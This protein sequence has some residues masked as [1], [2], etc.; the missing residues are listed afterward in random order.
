MKLAVSNLAWEV[1]GSDKIH[2]HLVDNGIHNV[3]GVLT[4][5]AGWE[6]LA[7]YMLT[8]HKKQLADK[9]ISI[10]TLQAIFYNSPC[11]DLSQEEDVLLHFSKVIWC[12]K[13]LGTSILVFGA[14][15]LRRVGTGT[16]SDIATLFK[17]LD[18]LLEGTG[19]TVVIEPNAREYGGEFFYTVQ[20][21][22]E[23]IQHNELHNVATMI[24]T[25]N[26]YLENTDPSVELLQYFS[27]IKHIH[28][29][30]EG[31]QPIS[32]VQAHL[33]FTKTLTYS[34][35]SGYLTYELLPCKELIQHISTFAQIYQS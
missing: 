20:E 1:E 29:S 30:E 10:P 25:H 22:V 11:K 31:L 32:E 15:K 21:I 12:A 26:S 34:K 14:P 19:I 27:Y 16:S 7:E 17:K 28:I 23:F 33:D 13:L 9:G 35:Y 5:L 18:M 3:E 4:K 6:D 24:D 8:S 2:S